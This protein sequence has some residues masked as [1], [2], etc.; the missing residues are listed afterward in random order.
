MVS[1][2]LPNLHPRGFSGLSGRPYAEPPGGHGD[3][4]G[5]IGLKNPAGKKCFKNH[6]GI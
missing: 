4:F 2:F 3:R 6:A 1:A 5:R